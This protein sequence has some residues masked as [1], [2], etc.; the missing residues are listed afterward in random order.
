MSHHPYSGLPMSPG[1]QFG[2]PHHHYQQQQQQR[3]SI[4]KPLPMFIAL[5]R[6]EEGEGRGREA[7]D[8]DEMNNKQQEETTYIRTCI[9][10]GGTT[11]GEFCKE[12]VMRHADYI[13]YLTLI[14]F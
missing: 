6:G 11:V 14:S 3:L 2:L 1:L 8:D 4:P 5:P 10:Y 7:E 12:F 9:N 13:Y